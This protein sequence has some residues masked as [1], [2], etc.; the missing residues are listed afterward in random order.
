MVKKIKK[1]N[2]HIFFGLE[3]MKSKNKSGGQM[4]KVDDSV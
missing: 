2:R 1:I 4:E 3:N